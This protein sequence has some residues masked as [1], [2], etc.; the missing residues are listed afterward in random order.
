MEDENARTT[1]CVF[2]P[3]REKIR[4]PRIVAIMRA[5]SHKILCHMHRVLNVDEK[6]LIVQLGEKSRDETLEPN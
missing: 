4:L 2:R 3:L 5:C 1:R 6:K